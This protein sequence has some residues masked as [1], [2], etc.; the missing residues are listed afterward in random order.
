MIFGGLKLKYN[1]P[2]AFSIKEHEY[3]DVPP[4]PYIST[5]DRFFYNNYSVIEEGRKIIAMGRLKVHE[6]NVMNLAES[7]QIGEG[8]S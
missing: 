7:K 1:E 8:Y 5:S 4:V 2:V 6:I 3:V